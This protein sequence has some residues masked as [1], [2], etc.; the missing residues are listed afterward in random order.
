MTVHKAKGLEFPV[1][2][3]VDPTAPAPANP[4]RHVDPERR[5]CAS[6]PSPA[7][8]PPSCAS[9]RPRCSSATRRGHPPRPTSPRPARATCWSCPASAMSAC[10]AGSTCCTRR[11]TRRRKAAPAPAAAAGCPA[12]GSDTLIDR[13]AA[14][15]A[16][17]RRRGGARAA[18]PRA[19][20]PH[21]SSGGIPSRWS[22]ARRTRPACASRRS[23]RTT[24]RGGKSDASIRAHDLWQRAGPRSSPRARAPRWSRAP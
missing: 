7:A 18:P 5:L 9:A 6:S 21:A 20:R 19:W 22:W 8:C 4:S 14:R 15:A 12:F 23:S 3:L 10:P 13:P 2:I 16:L 11:S 24:R 1:V 17:A